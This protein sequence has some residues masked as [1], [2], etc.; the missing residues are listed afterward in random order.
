MS[1]YQESFISR[2]Y[3]VSTVDEFDS[4]SSKATRNT[5]FDGKEELW[6]C[7]ASRKDFDPERLKGIRSMSDESYVPQPFPEHLIDPLEWT[8]VLATLSTCT[9]PKPIQFCDPHHYD[10]VPM[11]MVHPVTG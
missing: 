8:H 11:R 3:T 2:C 10:I 1:Q 6:M 7:G 5:I 4:A 9:L